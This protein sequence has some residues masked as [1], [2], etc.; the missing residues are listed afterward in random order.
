MG[1]LAAGVANA[2]IIA[3]IGGDYAT[4][5]GYVAG[6]TAPTAAPSGW[7]YLSSTAAIGGTESAL[8]AQTG[9][10][11]G[12]NDGFGVVGISAYAVGVLG[13]IAGGAQ[14]EMFDDGYDG[15]G[16]NRPLGNEGV[17]GTDLLLQPGAIAGTEYMIAR[18]TFSA[19]DILNG[20]TATI[21]G[22][23]RELTGK[24]GA[25]SDSIIA[26]VYHNTTSLFSKEG[27]TAAGTDGYLTQADGTFNITGLTVAEGDTVS[28][29][30]FG[31]GN[32][33]SDET[34]LNG[35]ITVI[36]EPATFGL[37]AV[38]GGGILFVRRRFTI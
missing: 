12:G 4:A 29:V 37:I 22:S 13:G 23:F 11:N 7:A 9:I 2:E 38:F 17:V 8:T 14:Y 3:D 20:T 6:T 27:G 32:A 10:G 15:N 5:T 31:N 24:T 26:S 33:T 35:T 19:A 28:F 36:P 1:L 21:A 34:A 25:N 18:Y 16:G 30:V